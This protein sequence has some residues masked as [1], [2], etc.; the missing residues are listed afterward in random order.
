MRSTFD[1][2]LAFDDSFVDTPSEE[3]SEIRPIS[4]VGVWIVIPLKELRDSSSKA[5]GVVQVCWCVF[6]KEKG[7]SYSLRPSVANCEQPPCNPEKSLLLYPIDT[8]E[9]AA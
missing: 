9:S 7:P 6:G 2:I 1:W 3:S 8:W 5:F 4:I